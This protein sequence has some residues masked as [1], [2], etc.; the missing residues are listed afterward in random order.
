[1]LGYK[2]LIDNIKYVATKSSPQKIIGQN[3]LVKNIF[4][5]LSK[6][7]K[8]QSMPLL[9]CTDYGLVL[10]F[11]TSHLKSDISGY[12]ISIDSITSHY[13][14]PLMHDS[15]K[16]Y[17]IISPNEQNLIPIINSLLEDIGTLLSIFNKSKKDNQYLL[18]FF[19][20]VHNSIS[21]YDKDANLLFANDNFCKYLSIEDRNCSIGMNIRNIMENAGLKAYSMEN[22]SSRLKM[23][24][25]LKDGKEV[26]DWE[27]RIESQ[28]GSKV[29]QLA[30]NDMYPVLTKDGEIEGMVEISRSR[31]RDMKRTRKILGLSAE[32]SFDD[33][34]GSSSSI[35]ET[36]RQAKKFGNSPFNFL[37][38]GESGV[39]KE[40]FVQSIHNY[41][42]RRKGPFVAL[43]C[44]SF[45]EG[46]IES[47]LFGY[48]SGAFTGASKKGQTGKFELADQGTLFLDEIAELP[49][50][51]Q[52]K[53]LR[54]L[55]TLIVTRIGSSQQIPVNVRVIAA[56]NKNL[57]DMISEGLFR[58]DLYYRLA[59]LNIEIPPLRE[60]GD[61]ILLLANTFLHESIHS[62]ND[63]PKTLDTDAQKILLEYNWPG[64]IRELK[65]VINRATIFSKSNI[66]TKDILGIVM[67]SKGHM[68]SYN[69]N[70]TP[71]KRLD[72]RRIEIN[73]SYANLLREALDITN[74]NKKRAA[75]ILGVSRKTLYRMLEKYS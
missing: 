2:N 15:L 5:F 65:N 10:S 12:T 3:F 71:E 43:N 20:S 39:G 19:N 24:D 4:E 57:K 14:K 70:I 42:P 68:L 27:V 67:H 62:S 63:T 53:L 16:G 74:G 54:V 8:L 55:E 9:L 34:T 1:M 60:R 69:E 26:L 59:V 48:V 66:I 29:D 28:D 51:F 47:E 35:R 73:N 30:S 18:N 7:S 40:L 37:V 36:I 56:T 41:S 21:L 49:F 25:V 23:L 58:E 46:L 45:P 6:D 17:I 33:I 52:A 44:A 50:H 38:T 13:D 61:D 75:E 31:Q 11:S 22:N 64:N 32:Y 72:Q